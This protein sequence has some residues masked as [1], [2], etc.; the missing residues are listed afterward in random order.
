LLSLCQF[1]KSCGHLLYF[2]HFDTSHQEK[3]GNPA[4]E[5]D[6]P[7]QNN[8]LYSIIFSN[9]EQVGDQFDTKWSRVTGCVCEKIAQNVAQAFLVKNYCMTLI[10]E[11]V[12][13]KCGLLL[14]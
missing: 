8:T 14:K 5:G 13:P 9:E 12:A 4:S 10:V 6:S 11:K 2:S 3:S 7:V 1:G